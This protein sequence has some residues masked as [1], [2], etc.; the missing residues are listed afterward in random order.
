M[1]KISLSDNTKCIISHYRMSDMPPYEACNLHI[2]LLGNTYPHIYNLYC[3][4]ILKCSFV[5]PG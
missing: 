1:D 4:Q 2:D 5:I 3:S